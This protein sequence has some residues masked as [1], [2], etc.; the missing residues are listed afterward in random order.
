MSA[1]PF[2][3]LHCHSHYSLLDGASRIPDLVER[4]KELGMNALALTD[5]GNLYG[6]LELYR[7]ARAAGI[8]PILGY[9]AYVAPGHRTERDARGMKEAAFHLTLLAK[10]ATG[11]RNLVKMASVAFLEG[12]YYRPRIDKDLLATH[13]E[14]LICLSG[15]ASS[16][17]STLIL[18]DQ[19]DQAIALARWLA[20]LFGEEHF[21]IEVQNAGLEIQRRHAEVA[22]DIAADLGLPLVAT[23]DAHYLRQEDAPAHDV[24]LCINTGKFLS[25]TGRMRMDGNQFYLCSPAE[26]QTRFPNHE[27]ALRHT[28]EIADRCDIQLELGARHFPVFRPPGKKTAEEY[29][30]ELCD[31]GLRTRYGDSPPAEA[32]ARL[33]HE[34]QTICS[35]GFASYFLIV[36]DFCRFARE[37]GI[38]YGARGS[39]CGALV[40]YVLHLSHVD[41]LEY[42]LLFERFL[43]ASR[44]EAPDIDIDF[45]QDRRDEVIRYVKEK[46]GEENVAQIGTFGTMA[47]RA[48][49]RDVGRVLQIPLARV[50]QIAK[51]IPQ[52]PPPITLEEALEASADLRR[53]YEGDAQVREMIQIGMRLEGL[54]RQAST[55]AA[56]VVVADRPL[57]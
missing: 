19:T 16:E 28:Q 17:F 10:N 55:H 54:A 48:V 26:M 2:V 4:T 24:L 43:D 12:F 35:M 9:E 53:E 33:E 30:R 3:H 18:R 44:K 36:W 11:F 46:Y 21:Y 8:N 22:C 49:V 57:T 45:C 25:D 41:P 14:G 27:E 34:L 20:K 1:P 56:G 47:A 13:H 42:D 5:H 29:L 15:C 31:E 39:A 37:Q 50:D 32:A 51:L 40:S 7:F 6:A 38:P 23:A 52:P